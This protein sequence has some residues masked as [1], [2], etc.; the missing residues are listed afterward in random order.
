MN[1]KFDAENKKSIVVA[2]VL[3]MSVA[4]LF[5]LVYFPKSRELKRLTAEYKDVERD[6]G[7]LYNFIGGRENL[8]DNIIEKRKELVLLEQALPSEKEVSNTIKQLNGEAKRFKIDVISLKPRDLF[9]YKDDEGMELKILDYFCK[10]MPL[11]LSIESRYQDLGEFLM[12]ME[13]SRNPMISIVMVKIEKNKDIAPKIKAI[14]DL[15]TFML[16]K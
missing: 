2:G 12:S 5:Q 3:I 6:I 7:E 14:I 11:R 16:G 9:L 15:N 10:Y 4:L 1:I 8:K 13:T